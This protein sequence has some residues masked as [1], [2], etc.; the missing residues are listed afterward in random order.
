MKQVLIFEDNPNLQGDN[1]SLRLAKSIAAE[2]YDVRLCDGR[3]ISR[4]FLDANKQLIVHDNEKVFL[5]PG[6]VNS[7]TPADVV[8]WICSK[9]ANC[10][11]LVLVVDLQFGNDSDYGYKIYQLLYAEQNFSPKLEPIVYSRWVNDDT[12]AILLKNFHTIGS[13]MLQRDVD[14]DE[15]VLELINEIFNP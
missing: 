7:A 5:Q 6:A 2:G 13:R 12:R 8:S 15:M 14:G 9:F 11:T 4:Y 3:T 1:K 10:D